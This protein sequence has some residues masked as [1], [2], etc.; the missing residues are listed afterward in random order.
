MSE[1]ELE[2]CGRCG[3]EVDPGRRVDFTL[4]DGTRVCDACF[5]RETPRYTEP[6][7]DWSN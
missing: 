3:A 5:V 1:T 2:T 4:S 6:E 7:N